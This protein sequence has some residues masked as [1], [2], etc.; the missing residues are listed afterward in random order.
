MRVVAPRDAFSKKVF[1]FHSPE[2]MALSQGAVRQIMKDL[3][4]I[5]TLWAL[6]SMPT[7]AW[8]TVKPVDTAYS[9]SNALKSYPGFT[10]N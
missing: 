3:R 4:G 10:R 9:R 6:S 1:Q 2:S 5:S 7:E 8:L